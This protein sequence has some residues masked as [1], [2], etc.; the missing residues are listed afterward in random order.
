MWNAVSYFE[1]LCSKLKATNNIYHFSRVSGLG[2]L[3]DVLSNFASKN[4]Y[5]AVDDTDDGATIQSG[6]SFFNRRSVV[7][8][9]LKK[10]SINNMAQRE[11]VMNEA[12]AIYRD[13]LSRLILDQQLVD[14]LAYL[15]TSKV[16]YYEVPGFFAS[17]TAGLYFI[18]SI[19]EPVNLEYNATKWNA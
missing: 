5:F 13:V 8:Y 2:N 1:N 7:V 9:I 11:T 14:D 15:D 12:R 10:Y 19:D 4:A 18:F 3:E 6:G 16:T 17:G